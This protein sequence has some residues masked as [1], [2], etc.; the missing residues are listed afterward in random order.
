MRFK[1][2]RTKLAGVLEITPEKLGDHRGSLTRLYDRRVFECLNADLNT[3]QENIFYTR[4]KNTMRGLHFSLPP[5]QESKMITAIRGVTQWVSVDL[6][7]SSPTFGAW[8]SVILLG[9]AHN[10]L[11]AGAG[12]A[13][14]CLSL[15]DD[16]ELLVKADQFFENVNSDGI[17]W[18]D[19]T[20]K[21]KWELKPGYLLVISEEHCKYPTFE[22]FLEKH[23]GKL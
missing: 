1:V 19:P 6:R 21:V 13:H 5:W 4:K 16:C 9:V 14:G 22:E 11:I 8:E 15:T 2:R 3:A 12:F 7:K 20:L 17:I 18:D 10:S 23:G